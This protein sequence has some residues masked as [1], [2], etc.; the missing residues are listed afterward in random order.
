MRALKAF[1]LGAFATGIVGYAVAAGLAV[2]AQA[3][4]RALDVA[5]GPIVV[6]SVVVDGSTTT[7]TFGAGL[8]LIAVAGGLLNLLAARVIARHSDRGPI[9]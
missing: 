5:L 7:T 6:V 9:A 2:A 1:A 8:A 3:D 4:G